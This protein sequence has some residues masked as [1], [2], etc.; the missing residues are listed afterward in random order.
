MTKIKIQSKL[1]IQDLTQINYKIKSANQPS[2][3]IHRTK[4]LINICS[5]CNSLRTKSN[6]LSRYSKI[7]R[8][9]NTSPKQKRI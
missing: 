5:P 1:V 9:Q 3:I 2:Y 6:K 8:K 4:N 7:K